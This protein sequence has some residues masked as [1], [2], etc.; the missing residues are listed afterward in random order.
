MNS[1]DTEARLKAIFSAVLEVPLADV[2]AGLCPENC[3]KWDSLNHI[4]LV[5]GIEEEFGIQL[6][7]ED[8]MGLQS[9]DQATA[10]VAKTVAAG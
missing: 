1:T 7:F 10:I 9:F 2:G 6:A 8:Q 3:A 4:H 5:N